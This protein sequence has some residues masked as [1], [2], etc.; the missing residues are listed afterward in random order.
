MENNKGKAV[1]IAGAGLCGLSAAYYLCKKGIT[2]VVFSRAKTP[3]GVFQSVKSGENIFDVYPK[4]LTFQSPESL[5]MSR[6]L[7]PRGIKSKCFRPGFFTEAGLKTYPKNFISAISLLGLSGSLSFLFKK[8][9]NP[10]RISGKTLE[11][12][13]ANRVGKELYGLFIKGFLEKM[14]GSSGKDLSPSLWANLA[15]FMSPIGENGFTKGSGSF[16]PDKEP[17]QLIDKLFSSLKRKNVK[18]IFE[19]SLKETEIARN[20]VTRILVGSKD[21]FPCRLVLA[22]PAYNLV[23]S[24][25]S[26]IPQNIRDAS[27]GLRSRNLLCAN[28]IVNAQAGPGRG[29]VL[30]S[31]P[32]I[33]ASIVHFFSNTRR[34][35][36]RSGI[37]LL[38]FCETKD[39][40]WGKTDEEIINKA[41]Y[42][43][44]IMNLSEPKLLIK[45]SVQRFEE[46]FPVRETGYED[47]INLIKNYLGQIKNIHLCELPAVPG[48]VDYEMASGIEAAKS[49]LKSI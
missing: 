25:V 37:T 12:L 31:N 21:Y 49:A 14:F 33:D 1:V 11:D 2:P 43:L 8:S 20:E 47:K 3:G 27:S 42:E 15:S 35:D 30:I 18:F 10:T 45:G 41:L 13:A 40:L 48:L 9:G 36:T 22:C 39:G 4:N 29:P 19:S 24:I 28:L 26:L 46:V 17:L 32:K 23:N 6:E 44:K 7:Y 16:Y 34:K 5:K 38:Y